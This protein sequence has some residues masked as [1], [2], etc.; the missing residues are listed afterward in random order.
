MSRLQKPRGI[1]KK[2][3]NIIYN[4]VH[5][6]KHIPSGFKKHFTSMIIHIYYVLLIVHNPRYRH[7]SGYPF[8]CALGVDDNQKIIYDM[9]WH[10]HCLL[11]QGN[12]NID[13]LHKN[14]FRLSCFA[15]DGKWWIKDSFWG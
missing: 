1:T 2:E 3:W 8:I 13:T 12:V 7:D 14:I 9:G 6:K 4:I 11:R 15:E 5:P 10:D